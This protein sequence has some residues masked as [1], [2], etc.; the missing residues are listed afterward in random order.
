MYFLRVHIFIIPSF[1]K[2][3]SL[4]KKLSELKF[5]IMNRTDRL[6]KVRKCPQEMELPLE[7]ICWQY[8]FKTDYLT[9]L[10]WGGGGVEGS[11]PPKWLILADQSIPPS[12]IYMVTIPKGMPGP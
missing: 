3:S 1:V 12:H 6:G 4:R 8:S 9:V 7:N 11:S 2:Y 10:I 5:Y